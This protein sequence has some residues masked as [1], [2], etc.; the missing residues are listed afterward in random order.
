M[1][2]MPCQ[3]G[4]RG[5]SC[6]VARAQRGSNAH[7]GQSLGSAR[8][9]HRAEGTG[10][11]EEL[12]LVE[13][14]EC[15]Q[16]LV[17][18]AKEM[19]GQWSRR[20]EVVAGQGAD[21]EVMCF[22]CDR[23]ADAQDWLHT[24]GWILAEARREQ[25]A[26]K[27]GRFCAAGYAVVEE[28]Q[29]GASVEVLFELVVTE[30]G[31]PPDL[32]EEEWGPD[33]QGYGREGQATEQEQEVQLAEG[34]KDVV[35]MGGPRHTKEAEAE[36]AFEDVEAPARRV[37]V[38]AEEVVEEAEVLGKGVAEVADLGQEGIDVEV[39]SAVGGVT[40]AANVVGSA[41]VGAKQLWI[42]ARVVIEEG[43]LHGRQQLLDPDYEVPLLKTWGGDVLS[44]TTRQLSR[45]RLRR[46]KWKE[47]RRLFDPGGKA[48]KK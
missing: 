35:G 32:E 15:L 13:L 8:A 40:S 27:L 44:K 48:T 12:E 23:L 42:E 11:S 36:A 18:E 16:M 4:A 14:M 43:A 47:R 37:G 9:N 3:Q 34:A 6:Q 20:L 25:C 5:G 31:M 24:C 17:D 2:S 39:V 28:A 21:L 41:V 19:A 30:V 10:V 45:R 1:P 26:K 29:W 33:S 7:L 22:C 46:R 38:D